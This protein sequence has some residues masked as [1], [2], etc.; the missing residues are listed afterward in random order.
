[1][2]L[3]GLCFRS[4][5]RYFEKSM[6]EVAVPYSMDTPNIFVPAQIVYALELPEER[7]FSYGVSYMRSPKHLREI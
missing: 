6:I 5:E 3:G 7:N 4:R 2:S 1:M